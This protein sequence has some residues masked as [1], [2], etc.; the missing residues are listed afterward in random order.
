VE[1]EDGDGR[2]RDSQEGEA[3]SPLGLLSMLLLPGK[4]VSETEVKRA[5]VSGRTERSQQ[6]KCPLYHELTATRGL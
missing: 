2:Q 6:L 1:L 4:Q 3:R 5:E